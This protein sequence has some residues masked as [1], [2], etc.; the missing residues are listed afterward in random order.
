MPLRIR[1]PSEKRASVNRKPTGEQPLRLLVELP[2]PAKN[3]ERLSGA[4]CCSGSRNASQAS[5]NEQS[6]RDDRDPEDQ[7]DIARDQRHQPD[8]DDRRE[9]CAD[10]VERLPQAEARPRISGGRFVGDHRVARAPRM[11]LPMRSAKRAGITAARWPQREQRLRQSREAIAGHHPRLALRLRSDSR[12]E[13][14]LAKLA[15]ASASPSIAPSAVAGS[16]ARA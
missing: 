1:K 5:R 2:K 16:R 11:P 13:N 12:P 3:G 14:S 10:R 15:V 6:G 7:P 4:R 8:R 9:Q